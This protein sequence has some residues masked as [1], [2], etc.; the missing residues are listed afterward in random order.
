MPIATIS[1]NKASS[2]LAISSEK[3]AAMRAAVQVAAIVASGAPEG[4][5]RPVQ[6]YRREQ[7]PGDHCKRIAEQHLVRVPARVRAW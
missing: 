3:G 6:A 5:G 7:K 4:V 2:P 1:A